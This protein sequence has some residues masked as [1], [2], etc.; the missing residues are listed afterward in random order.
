VAK[1]DKNP[2]RCVVCSDHPINKDYVYG[3]GSSYV[4]D[5]SE[6]IFYCSDCLREPEILDRYRTERSLFEKN[7]SKTNRNGELPDWQKG[8][9]GRAPLA[10]IV[11][12]F[13]W[14]LAYG[15]S[16]YEPHNN[17]PAPETSGEQQ[18][19]DADNS[20]DGPVGT[21]DDQSKP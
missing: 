11:V 2:N 5:S 18:E 15:I 1:R 7:S 17:N 10:I 4:N 12:L 6:K 9:L 3:S 19:W 21:F 16:N 20:I 13:L 14:F 8:P